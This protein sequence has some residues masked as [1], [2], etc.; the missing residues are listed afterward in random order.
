MLIYILL[1]LTLQVFSTPE[2]TSD[3]LSITKIDTPIVLDGIPDEEIWETIQPLPVVMYQPVFRGDMTEK[4]IIKVAYDNEYVYVMGQLYDSEPDKITTNSLYRD[5]YSGDDTFAIV[6]DSYNDSENA[7]WFFTTPAGNKTDMQISNDAEGED[8]NNRNWNTFWDSASTTTD[9]GWFVEMRI[10][11]SSLGFQEVNN[12]VIMG[13]IVY[14]YIA[15]KAERHVFPAI[16]ADWNR[17]FA[18]PSQAQK[19]RL[20]GIDYKKPYYITPYVLGG[21]DQL[22]QLKSTADGYK[23]KDDLTTEAGLDIKIPVSGNMN[24]DITVN[25]D[26]AQVEAD[27]AQINLTRTPLFFP[28]KRQFFQERSDIFDFNLGGSNTLFYSRRIGLDEGQQVRILGGARLAGRT[29]KWDV[30]L[31]NM[32]TDAVSSLDIESRNFG[33]LRARRDLINE[34]SYLGGIVT[35]RMGVDGSYNIGTGLDFLYNYSGDHFI[36]FKIAS[37]F[38]DSFNEDY[39][40]LDNSNFRLFLNKRTSS[41]FYYRS[42]LKRAGPRYQPEMGFESR[43]DYTLFDARIFYGYFN[44][45]DSPLR[46]V[47][48][49][50]RYLSTFRN[51]DNSIESMLIEHPWEIKF[52]NEA[53]IKITASWWYEDLI[54]P[55]SFSEKTFVE[56][57]SYSFFGAEIEYEMSDTKALRSKFKTRISKFYDGEQYSISVSPTWNQS[58]HLEISGDI[59]LNYLNFSSRDQSEFLN[60]YRLRSLIAL[61]TKVSLQLLSQYNYLARQIATNARFRYNF[62][63]QNDL[64]IVYNEITN[65]D[66]ERAVPTLPTFDSRVFLIKYTYTFH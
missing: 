29:G 52:K 7:K 47:T 20:Q 38:D 22:N 51:D 24:L 23:R 41:G 33:V 31:L 55:L 17:G 65:T 6:L 62:A 1:L 44:S 2:K 37:T 50:L 13:M 34:N 11:F 58:R 61:N 10:P 39:S 48:P 12:E 16:P 66:I 5:R 49:G 28:E 9:E 63:E 15:R 59:E 18:K 25:T 60:I 26:F 27:E 45:A 4:S 43:T 3:I 14:R 21:F 32:Q 35:T 42:T 40:L 53:G 36:D 46:I 64:W 8:S 30:G 54:E 19:I 56:P 57:G